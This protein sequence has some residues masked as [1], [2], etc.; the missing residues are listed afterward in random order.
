M[1]DTT[2]VFTAAAEKV[3]QQVRAFGDNA[4]GGVREA[5]NLVLD[6]YEKGVAA[7][8]DMQHKAAEA[9]PIDVLKT[10]IEAHTIFVK[11]ITDAYVKAARSALN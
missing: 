3:N 7:Y 6:S 11:E 9:T 5:G 8:L 1:T 10:A 2:E 4:A